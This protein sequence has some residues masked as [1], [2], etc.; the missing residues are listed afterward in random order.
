MT[1]LTISGV[2][3]SLYSGRGPRLSVLKRHAIFELVEVGGVDL[4]ERRIAAAL[5]VA[6]VVGPFPV[7][8][9]GELG[10]RRLAGDPVQGEDRDEQGQRRRDPF[11]CSR[12]VGH[13]FKP[14]T[15]DTSKRGQRCNRQAIRASCFALVFESG[16]GRLPGESADSAEN[17]PAMALR[18]SDYN[19]SMTDGTAAFRYAFRTL[20]RQ[21]T[22]TIV[23][24]LTLALGIG[25]NTAIF[26]VIKTVVLNP[27][28]TNRP[29]RSRSSGR[30]IRTA[31]KGRVSV[32]TFED[33]KREA[34]SFESLAAYRHVDLLLHA[35]RGDPQNVPALK[36]TP[37]LFN[38][39]KSQAALGRHFHRRR[40]RRRQRSRR[41][42]QPRLLARALGG[43]CRRDREDHPTRLRPL[44]RRRRDAAGV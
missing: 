7:L 15:A 33:W 23:A 27:L 38:V 26:S 11:G 24:I 32:P 5:D 19:L 44:H 9:A 39:L 28:P 14:I 21:P 10:A 41:R 40:S 13:S 36:A 43:G 18:P 42:A 3:S 17:S 6:A 25:A 12:H 34:K 37:D 1:P 4:I 20:R 29:R 35:G 2:P 22:F 30:S 31:I 8:G 16:S